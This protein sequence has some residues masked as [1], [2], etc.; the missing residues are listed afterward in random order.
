MKNLFRTAFLA[1]FSFGFAASCSSE[2][3]PAP[4][5]QSA[6]GSGGARAIGGSPGSG[7]SLL[8]GAGAAA[9]AG[10]A[11]KQVGAN[12]GG[13]SGANPGSDGATAGRSASDAGASGAGGQGGTGTGQAGSEG[14]GQGGV[15]ARTTVAIFMIDG[16]MADAA[17]TAAAHG[18]T[19]LQFVI[20]N[21]VTVQTSHSTSPTPRIELPGG[22]RPW[23]SATS[24]NVSAHTGTHLFEAPSAGMDDIFKATQAA[25]IRSVYSGGDANY[26]IFKSATFNY[27][28]KLEDA[29]VVQRALDHL[30]NDGVR[31]LRLHLQRVRDHWKGTADRTNPNSAYLQK[32]V[33]ADALLG[34]L[35]SALKDSGAW[36][37]TYLIVAADHGMASAGGGTHP[38][39]AA[40][41]WNPF[42]AFYG[43]DLKKGETIPYAELPDIAVTTMR[44]FRLPPLQGHTSSAVNLVKKG[45]TG[46]MLTNL[47]LGAPSELSHPRYIEHYLKLGTFA[48]D[49]DTFAPYRTA[50]LDL[51]R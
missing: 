35:I 48:S 32:I 19:N 43:P 5:A 29:V 42:M 9:T 3:T 26:A 14:S 4:T 18:A 1:T 28:A 49:G 11:G 40:A 34:Q 50:M 6:S 51:V 16:L 8:S 37:H 41:S 13:A 17:K 25:G 47:F 23:G 24:G 10:A 36:E 27:G 45:A 21:G 39:T 7:G 46:T 44:F 38:A 12:S 22:T 31:L 20:E 33:S 15:D 30:K 2:K